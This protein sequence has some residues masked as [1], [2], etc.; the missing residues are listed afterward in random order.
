MAAT[1][2][3]VPPAVVGIAGAGAMGS[4]IAE[5]AAAAG[6]SV[7]LFDAAP[8]AAEAAKT[9]IAESLALRAARGKIAPSEADAA[10]SRVTVV[11]ALA[12]L[13]PAAL[14]IEAIAE[15]QAAKRGLLAALETVVGEAAVLATN[16]SSLSVTALARGLRRPER[17]AGLHFFNP[18][19]AMK[20]VEIVRGNATAESVAALLFATAEAWGKTPVHVRDAPGFI[21]N[22]VARPFYLEAL[23][24]YEDAGADPATLDAVVRESGGFRMGPF[25]LMDLIGHDVN[26]AVTRSL[27]EAFARDPRFAPSRAQAELVASGRL[28]KKSGQGIYDHRPGAAR[29]AP[30]EL[31]PGPGPKRVTIEGDLGPAE[32]LARAA[33]ASGIPCTRTPGEGRIVL[34]GAVLMP[35]DGRTAAKRIAEGG[36]RDLVLFDLAPDYMPARRI[37]LAT[38]AAT[39]PS[40]LAAAAGLIQAIGKKASPLPDEPALVVLRIVARLANE[41]AWAVEDGVAES[42]AVDT[43]MRAGA[44]Y[45]LGPLAWAAELGPARV[46]AA[47]AALA[48][49]HGEARYRASAQL[50]EMASITRT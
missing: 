11:D 38:A 7:L 19:P 9:R 49:A 22:R 23:A 14:A 17:F 40:A 24:L 42:E 5:V 15:D 44:N 34:D 6:H 31:P 28:G 35:S 41:A 18:A 50:R 32:S 12:G 10:V 13:A 1:G 4:G 25:E 45:P 2:A 29:R 16:T 30:E 43:A 8:G 39:P 27:F 3:L 20:L 47:L 48:E 21:V 37:G 33:V 46:L 26:L 36:P